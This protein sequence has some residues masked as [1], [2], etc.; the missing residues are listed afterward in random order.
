MQDKY[1]SDIYSERI[2]PAMQK[3]VIQSVKSC[4]EQLDERN[5]SVEVFGYDFMVD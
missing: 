5:N 2:K 1:K 3:I 4:N